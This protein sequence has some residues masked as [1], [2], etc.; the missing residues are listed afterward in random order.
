[1]RHVYWVIDKILGGRPGPVREPWDPQALYAG[2]I[3]TVV[4]LA[5]EE[6]VDDLSQYGLEHYRAA[7]PPVYL[8]SVGMRKA[9][10]HE[11]LPVWAFIHARIEAA[12]P[13]LVHCHAG[14]DRT[15]LILA[16]YLVL[17]HRVSPEEAVVRV[18]AVNPSAM[19]APGYS[20]AVTL[21]KPG[22]FPDP[23][24]LL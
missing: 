5:A 13:L 7:F 9:F 4:S 11:A 21:L 17:Y 2:G 6:P 16:G 3:R 12:T 18:Q 14:A 19:A 1:M 20:E 8:F 10:I 15:G 24:T 23:K 22:R